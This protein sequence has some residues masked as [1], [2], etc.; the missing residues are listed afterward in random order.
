MTLFVASKA[1][2][3]LGVKCR[4]PS[5][6]PLCDVNHSLPKYSMKLGSLD[7]FELYKKEIK[8]IK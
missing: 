4:T 1:L 7:G 2:F 8:K 5:Y 6:H 3:V